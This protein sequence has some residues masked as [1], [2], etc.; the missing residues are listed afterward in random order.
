MFVEFAHG[1]L[2]TSVV[3]KVSGGM[4]C[5][6]RLILDVFFRKSE[7]FSRVGVAVEFDDGPE[8][9]YA[10]NGRMIADK[11]ALENVYCFKGPSGF[12][13]CPRCDGLMIGALT[14]TNFPAARKS[15]CCEI[16]VLK[17]SAFVLATNESIIA[18]CDELK[19]S[20]RDVAAT[21]T[22]QGKF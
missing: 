21:K 3:E 17:K 9:L 15:N 19:K 12:S 1:V 11:D 10:V 4:S 22:H 18:L 20:H 6:Y 14:D 2:Q 7:S 13:P 5:I 8:I 16:D